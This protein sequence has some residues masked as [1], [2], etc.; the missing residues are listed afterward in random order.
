MENKNLTAVEWLINKHFGG[1]ENCTPDFK[2][3]IEQAK[4]MEKE[5]IIDAYCDGFQQGSKGDRILSEEYYNEI[6]K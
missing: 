5:Q 1:V 2:K 6:Y 4:Q 3:H